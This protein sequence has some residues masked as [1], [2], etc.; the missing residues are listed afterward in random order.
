VLVIVVAPSSY[1]AYDVFFLQGLTAGS[2]MK[3]L[4]AVFP[5]TFVCMETGLV[6]CIVLLSRLSLSGTTF[7]GTADA[8][9]GVLLGVGALSCLGLSMLPV[10]CAAFKCHARQAGAVLLLT[11]VAIAAVGSVKLQPYSAAMPKRVLLNHVQ[12]TQGELKR[13]GEVGEHLWPEMHVVNAAW[14]ISGTDP[15][16]VRMV[17]DA[18][19]IPEAE[20][21]AGRAREWL[22]VYPISDLLDLMRF[23]APVVPK[24]VLVDRLPALRVVSDRVLPMPEAAGNMHRGGQHLQDTKS[25]IDD[26]LNAT[27]TPTTREVVVE[28]YTEKPCWGS[29]RVTGQPLLSWELSPGGGHRNVSGFMAHG[30]KPPQRKVGG[31]QESGEGLAAW[32]HDFVVKWT[33]E[34]REMVWR[35]TLLLEGLATDAE[36]HASMNRSGSSRSSGANSIGPEGPLKFELHVAYLDRTQHLQEMVDR[37]PDWSTLSYEATTYVSEWDV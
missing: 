4:V 2:L 3:C 15:A 8:I 24:G 9:A 11:A 12:Y 34:K 31:V 28:V 32:P 7:I 29:L 36:G 17:T 13:G 18:M 5:A 16:S 10:I 19:G 25:L 20:A 37:M 26:M 27:S 6:T 35:I 30:Y 21:I 23:P 33:N 14:A 1:D 22:V